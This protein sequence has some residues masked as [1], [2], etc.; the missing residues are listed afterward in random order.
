MPITSFA[1]QSDI[2][3]LSDIAL[4]STCMQ[5]QAKIAK[6]CSSD[7]CFVIPATGTWLLRATWSASARGLHDLSTTA[8]P[9][10]R[11]I[12]RP[13]ECTI[14]NALA[15]ST[16]PKL[17]VWPIK[18]MLPCM[19]LCPPSATN[20]QVGAPEPPSHVLLLKPLSSQM[21]PNALLQCHRARFL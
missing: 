19:M 21:V 8:L 11:T 5:Y 9:I 18:N 10:E 4:V 15:A 17:P 16:N 20:S 6:G 12:D 7:K 2:Q 14:T 13:T 1:N 3:Y